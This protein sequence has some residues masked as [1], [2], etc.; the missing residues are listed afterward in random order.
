MFKRLWLIDLVKL[1]HWGHILISQNPE[2]ASDI[3]GQSYQKQLVTCTYSQT[4]KEK[5]QAVPTEGRTWFFF[6]EKMQANCLIFM[7]VGRQECSVY[8]TLRTLHHFLG[9]AL[10]VSLGNYHYWTSSQTPISKETLANL[11]N[12]SPVVSDILCRRGKFYSQ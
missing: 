9:C 6:P 12:S 7:G 10:T 1:L 8:S 5:S 3:W 11:F 2:R 4:V